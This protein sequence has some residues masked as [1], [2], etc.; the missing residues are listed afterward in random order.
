MRRENISPQRDIYK[1]CEVTQVSE[2][3]FS[4]IR[5]KHTTRE[6]LKRLGNKGESYEN[7]IEWLLDNCKKRRKR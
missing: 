1:P 3:G 4:S 6:R 2:G 7:V 5:V